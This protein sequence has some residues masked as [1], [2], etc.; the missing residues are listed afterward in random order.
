MSDLADLIVT[1][2]RAYRRGDVVLLR[3]HYPLPFDGFVRARATLDAIPRKTGVEFVLLDPDV[4]VVEPRE[5][6]R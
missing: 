2:G 6:E 3:C 1:E 5:V 4:E